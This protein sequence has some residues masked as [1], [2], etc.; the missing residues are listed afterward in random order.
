VTAIAEADVSLADLRFDPDATFYIGGSQGSLVGTA[1][2]VGDDRLAGAILNVGAGAAGDFLCLPAGPLEFLTFGLQ[3]DLDLLGA[4]SDGPCFHPNVMLA[5]WYLEPMDSL[6]ISSAVARARVASG[7]PPDV[8][9]QVADGDTLI[10]PEAQARWLSVAELP[11]HG[12]YPDAVPTVELP[13][14]DNLSAGG[15]EVT[16]AGYQFPGAGHGMLGWKEPMRSWDDHVEPIEDVH[17]QITHFLESRLDT[18]SAEI[19]AP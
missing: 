14:S 4:P 12:D 2:M 1:A 7:A 19:I 16:A 5:Q 15:G 17:A 9:V 6:A 8:L 11:S 3:G 13:A 10:T 18:G